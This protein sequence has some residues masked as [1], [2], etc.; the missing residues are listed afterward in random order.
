MA[1]EKNRLKKIRVSEISLV[2]KASVGVPGLNKG[3]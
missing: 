1:N 3:Q 2:D